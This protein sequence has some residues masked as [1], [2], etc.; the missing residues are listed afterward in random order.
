MDDGPTRDGAYSSTCVWEVHV[1]S[2]SRSS[3]R[4]LILLN[5]M[6]WPNGRDPGKFLHAFRAAAKDGM[7]PHALEPLAIG[8]ESF[9]W[10]DGVAV[11]T[12]RIS[13]G[14]SVLIPDA[15]AGWRRARSEDLAGLV[16][17]GL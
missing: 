9:W 4:R 5:A 12:G 14:V 1:E 7:I 2:A 15:D 3:A 13:Y 17:S 16:A 11:R 10:G 8:D 6:R